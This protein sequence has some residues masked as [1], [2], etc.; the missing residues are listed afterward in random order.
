MAASTGWIL[1]VRSPAVSRMAGFGTRN[2]PGVS[3]IP[4]TALS[5]KRT[6][7]AR[8]PDLASTHKPRDSTAT[9]AA[10]DEAA[11]CALLLQHRL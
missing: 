5:P 4:W 3:A 6:P 7:T 8:A 11:V 9:T 2:Q 10:A 1:L